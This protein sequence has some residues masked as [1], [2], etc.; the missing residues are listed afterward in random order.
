MKD[1]EVM[2]QNLIIS[3][4]EDSNTVV[5]G[6]E[7]LD[8]FHH[9]AKRD[10]VKRTVEKKTTDVYQLMLQELNSV[11]IEF[12]TNRKTP[13]ILRT[14]PDYAGSAYWAKALLLRVQNSMNALS[15]AYYL[16]Q[17]PLSQDAKAQYELLVGSL[18]EYI[19][20]THLE[21]VNSI[22]ATLVDKLNE[23]LMAR[24]GE[25]LQI[26][27]DKDLLRFFAETT[28]FQKL[29]LD[30]PFQFQELNSKKEELRILR[31]NVLLVVREYNGIVET[32]TPQEHLLFKERIR[33]ID[34]KINAGLTTLNW[35]I[36]LTQGFKRNHRFLYQRM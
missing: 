1:L 32:L 14:Q 9:L 7:L 30:I 4:F 2:M 29:K 8:I 20:K 17:T 28:Y 22:P 24:R 36:F 18:E 33:F 25:M 13:L 6:V 21:W 15:N 16:P 23:V 31:E 34:R 26:K 12:E 35:Y 10:A 11:K 5:S 3:A 19:S 27:F